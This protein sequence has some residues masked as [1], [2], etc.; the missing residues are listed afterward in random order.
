MRSPNAII[1]PRDNGESFSADSPPIYHP[2]P[3][4]IPADN[5]TGRDNNQGF[6]G[7]TVKPDGTRL[8]T[9]LLSATN[10]DGGLKS[11][12]SRNARLVVY[13][14]TTFQP[15]YLA[16]YVVQ[17]NHVFPSDTT[18]KVAHQSETHCIPATQFMIL[19]R[20]SGAGRGQTNT[21]SIYRHV[22]IFDTSNATNVKGAAADCYTCEIAP[23]TGGLNSTIQPAQY[24]LY[25]FTITDD[26][27]ITQN[28]YLNF[29]R[30][31]YK[32]A[33]GFSLDNQTLV[34]KVKLPRG[35]QP[36]VS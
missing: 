28:G 13:D 3:A 31:Q 11:K 29:G 26:D 30:Y 27:L 25:L 22:D 20:D 12:N 5:P 2:K 23:S 21:Q 16:E 1:P 14:I 8:Y 32:D 36:L 34:F 19:A 10:Q 7:L 24:C 9:L 17:I 18:T 15:S 35:N 4:T 6:D 33:S